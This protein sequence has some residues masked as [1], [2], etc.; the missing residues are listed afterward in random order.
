M[1]SSDCHLKNTANDKGRNQITEQGEEKSTANRRVFD[2]EVRPLSKV[3]SYWVN[4]RTYEDACITGEVVQEE[5]VI[6][7]FH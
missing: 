1:Y 3:Q 6:R 2:A 7:A 5:G 4:R